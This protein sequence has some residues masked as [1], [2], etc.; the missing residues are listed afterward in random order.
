M[1]KT[2]LADAS[3][4][5]ASVQRMF[6]ESFG[7]RYRAGEIHVSFQRAAQSFTQITG[8]KGPENAKALDATPIG[9]RSLFSFF[10]R[11]SHA[12]V[13][14]LFGFGGYATEPGLRKGYLTLWRVRPARRVPICAFPRN[15]KALLI[16]KTDQPSR[17]ICQRETA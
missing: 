3:E 16:R 7:R 12:P 4:H 14:V 11:S 10:A 8:R 5:L 17:L 1:T 9:D 15:E 2:E 13:T 6:V